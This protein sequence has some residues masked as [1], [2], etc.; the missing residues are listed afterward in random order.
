MQ[1][2]GGIGDLHGTDTGRRKLEHRPLAVIVSYIS[3][4]ER[5]RARCPETRLA[6]AGKLA[7]IALR[8]GI[9]E[10]ANS[11]E[12]LV[13]E[14]Q[15]RDWTNLGTKIHELCEAVGGY[16]TIFFLGAVSDYQF[17]SSLFAPAIDC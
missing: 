3:Q 1:P 16:G 14:K 4:V 17:V 11:R 13:T 10:N 9:S 5:R 6:N 2:R 8:S 12:C 15:I 7:D